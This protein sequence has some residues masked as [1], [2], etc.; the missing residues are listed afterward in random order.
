MRYQ[1]FKSPAKKQIDR[2]SKLKR[3][4]SSGKSKVLRSR[5]LELSRIA[6]LP[7]SARY[8]KT[9]I[10]WR[11]RTK[12]REQLFF[13]DLPTRLRRF[14]KT[15]VLPEAKPLPASQSHGGVAIAPKQHVEEVGSQEAYLA[16]L[17]QFD[18]NIDT[19]CDCRPR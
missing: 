13:P 4:D 12:L 10:Q 14:Y 2:L 6:C 8:R 17:C 15:L 5:R 11:A 7:H 19:S 16:G 9:Q 1:L 18:L 3:S